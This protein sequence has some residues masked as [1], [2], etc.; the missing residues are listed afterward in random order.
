[1]SFSSTAKEEMLR[2]GADAPPTPSCCDHAELSALCATGG[3]ITLGHRG[4]G[5]SF[6]TR[7]ESIARYVLMQMRRLYGA[8]ADLSMSSG[9]GV[10]RTTYILKLQSGQAEPLLHGLKL[11][12]RT[13]DGF[14]TLPGGIDRSY[15]GRACCRKAYLRGAFLGA[16]SVSDPSSG[17]HM[18]IA[19]QDKQFAQDLSRLMLK[20]KLPARIAAKKSGF[21]VY[22]K[23]GEAIENALVMMGAHTAMLNMGNARI[24]KDVRNNVNRAVNCE[25]A[26]IEKTMDAARRQRLAIE[27]LMS[28]GTWGS[29]PPELQELGSLR[30]KYPE[31]TLIELGQML[32]KPVG[33]SGVNHR[34]RR[35]EAAAQQT[36]REGKGN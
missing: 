28:N 35:I 7:R 26:N 17:Y 6:S 8:D 4:M 16:G 19:V 32:D 13:P 33:K 31:A 11:I 2:L 1:M 36:A 10:Q 30:L 34:L 9:T 21:T 3:A 29:L 12:E 25:S 24:L 23:E 22:L 20:Q 15:L 14:W 5:F 27:Q 18:E